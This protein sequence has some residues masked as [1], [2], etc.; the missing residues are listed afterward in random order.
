MKC[1]LSTFSLHW[2]LKENSVLSWGLDTGVLM[3]ELRA[4]KW[5]ILKTTIKQY[6]LFLV[7]IHEEGVP[8]IV[9]LSTQPFPP[10][11]AQRP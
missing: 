3:V 6:M 7:Y 1:G 4:P 11:F 2:F 9:K 8:D 5:G 10:F